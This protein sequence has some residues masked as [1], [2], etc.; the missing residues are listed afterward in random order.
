[1]GEILHHQCFSA[2]F[3]K[4]ENILEFEKVILGFNQTDGYHP[5]ADKETAIQQ[6]QFFTHIIYSLYYPLK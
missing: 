5:P 1:L 3:K 2:L 6:F 4:E